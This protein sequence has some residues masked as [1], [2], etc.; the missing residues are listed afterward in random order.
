MQFI[1]RA[2]YRQDWDIR[3]VIRLHHAEWLT[4]ES[5]QA[6]WMHDAMHAFIKRHYPLCE[7]QHRVLFFCQSGQR[8]EYPDFSVLMPDRSIVRVFDVEVKF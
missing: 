6:E 4:F 8:A 3:H 7:V 2:I 5:H 1:V